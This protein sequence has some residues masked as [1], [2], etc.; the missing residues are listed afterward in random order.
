MLTTQEAGKNSVKKLEDSLRLV[1]REA[2]PVV[3]AN[4]AEVMVDHSRGLLEWYSLDEVYN[5]LLLGNLDLWVIIEGFNIKVAGIAAW[6]R[7]KVKSAYHLIWIGGK[8]FEVY[9]EA[10][11]KRFEQYAL[12]MNASDVVISGRW[13]WKRIL[14][15]LGYKQQCVQM[16]KN[17]RQTLGN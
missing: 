17:I 16:R 6:E 13:A 12:I 3:W 7:H 1:P 11:L 10:A 4:V 2:V 5:N 8:G 15:P 9:R 14:A